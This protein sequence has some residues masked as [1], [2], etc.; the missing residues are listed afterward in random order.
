MAHAGEWAR[1][2]GKDGKR[3]DALCDAVE[4]Y[5]ETGRHRRNK[6][7]TAAVKAAI[8]RWPDMHPVTLA[9][10]IMRGRA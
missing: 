1:L 7:V 6:T 2:H 3:A 4:H 5:R 10:C 8:E 9:I